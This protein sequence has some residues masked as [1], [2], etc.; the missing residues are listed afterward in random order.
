MNAQKVAFRRYRPRYEDDSTTISNKLII[1]N[2][3]KDSDFRFLVYLFSNRPDWEVYLCN[4]RKRLGW[5]R[6]KTWQCVRRLFQLGYIR[7]KQIRNAKGQFSHYDFEFHHDPIFFHQNLSKDS[8]IEQ[9]E[10][11]DPPDNE[12]EPDDPFGNTV[13]PQEECPH[14]QYEPET[15]KGDSQKETLP[16]PLSTTK[17]CSIQAPIAQ[18]R[19]LKRAMPCSEL[20]EKRAVGAMPSSNLGSRAMDGLPS[21][22]RKKPRSPHHEANFQ[23]LMSLEITDENGIVDE[24]EMS[25]LSHKYSK[26]DLENAYAHMAYKEEFQGFKP[27]SRLKIFKYLLK[28]EGNPMG[29]NVEKNRFYAEEFAKKNAWFSLEIHQKYCQDKDFSGMDLNLNMEPNLFQDSLL[30]LYNTITRN[31]PPAES[32]QDFYFDA[33][34]YDE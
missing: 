21:K 13:D 16:L 30:R 26:R 19:N 34:D 29:V 3:L 23:W 8:Y 9:L 33:R 14:N 25:W 1:N 32:E 28:N 2:S 24:N 11:N 10:E 6:K 4:V 18:S 20:N 22:Q 5:G 17:S 12:Y 7:M 27:K 31:R 15:L